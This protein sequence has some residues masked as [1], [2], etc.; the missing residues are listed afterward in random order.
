MTDK[1]QKEIFADNLL[2]YIVC[3]RTRIYAVLNGFD[4]NPDEHLRYFLH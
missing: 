1:E 4:E 3:L 2:F